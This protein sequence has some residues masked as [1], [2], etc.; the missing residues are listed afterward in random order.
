MQNVGLQR[1]YNNDQELTL[2]LRMLCAIAFLPPANVIQGFEE[3]VNEIRNIYNDEVDELP[4][5]FEEN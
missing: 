5:Y 1:R 2:H 4:N 3:L